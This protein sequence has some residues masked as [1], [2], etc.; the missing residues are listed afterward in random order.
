MIGPLSRRDI[1]DAWRLAALWRVLRCPAEA[2]AL[3]ARA[4]QY[5]V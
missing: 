5:C 2:E 4:G 1:E 3:E